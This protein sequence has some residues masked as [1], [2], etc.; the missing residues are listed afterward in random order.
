M[1]IKTKILLVNSD[2][3]KLNQMIKVFENTKDY[4]LFYTTNGDEA[5][6][7]ILNNNIDYLISEIVVKNKDLIEILRAIK[8]RVKFIKT[9]IYTDYYSDF[10]IKKFSKENITDII[11]A[12]D[13]NVLKNRVDDIY[14]NEIYNLKFGKLVNG[15]NAVKN[16]DLNNEESNS[17]ISGGSYFNENTSI[18]SHKLPFNTEQNSQDCLSKA[19]VILLESGFDLSKLGYRYILDAIKMINDDDTTINLITKSL[20]P[21]I[22]LK[23]DTNV[24][25]VE[26]NI[27]FAISKAYKNRE[28]TNFDKYF[29]YSKHL[30]SKNLQ[31][32]VFYLH[33]MKCVNKV[34]NF[35]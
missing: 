14:N 32:E 9:I 6:N 30:I 33:Y 34:F 21:Q 10:F 1:I 23:N 12:N 27:R 4:E 29:T 26:K 11:E 31:I 15:S 7:I 28:I 18:Y 3:L 19:K 20:Y 22:A 13:V 2:V 16:E 25:C 35:K 5:I 8:E 24:S 17:E